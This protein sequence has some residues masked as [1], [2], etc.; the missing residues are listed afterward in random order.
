MRK[1]KEKVCGRDTECERERRQKETE[2]QSERY[3][4]ESVWQRQRDRHTDRE[5]TE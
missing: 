2:R 1:K 4:E 5:K 3:E